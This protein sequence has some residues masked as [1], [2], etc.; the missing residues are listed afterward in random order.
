MSMKNALKSYIL[1]FG[2]AASVAHA[3]SIADQVISQLTA[4]GYE[5]IEIYNSGTEI[6]G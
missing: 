2:L 5:R 1:F 3:E 6:W 4:Q